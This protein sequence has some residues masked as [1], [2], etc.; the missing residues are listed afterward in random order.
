MIEQKF[1]LG[2]ECYYFANG[3]IEKG[4][5]AVARLVSNIRDETVKTIKYDIA[6]SNNI[7]KYEF[8]EQEKLFKTFDDAKH[9]LIELKMEE[10]KEITNLE[11][12]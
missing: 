10:I 7:L 11:E 1:E 6:T 5:I 2:E 12:R 4:K 8:V 3:G 9:Y